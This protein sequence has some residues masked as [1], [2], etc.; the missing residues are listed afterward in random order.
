MPSD[1]ATWCSKT[2]GGGQYKCKWCG[3]KKEFIKTTSKPTKHKHGTLIWFCQNCDNTT[4]YKI[5]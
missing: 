4:G 5:L 1:N 3:A 2:M